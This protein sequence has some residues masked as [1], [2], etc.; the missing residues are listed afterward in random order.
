MARTRAEFL[1]ATTAAAAAGAALPVRAQTL[2]PLRVGTAPADS[3]AQAWYAQ[4]MGFFTKAGLNV[5]VQLFNSGTA[6]ASAVAGGSLD[7]AIT[8]PIPLA[9]AHV[10]GVPFVIVCSATVNTP[11]APTELICVRKSGSIHQASDL[12]GKTA[13]VNTLRTLL[14][15]GLEVYLA[16]SN[17]AISSMRVVEMSFAEMGPAIDRGQI[18]A[19]VFTEPA[20]SKALALNDV[21]IL[22]DPLPLISPRFV[23]ACWFSTRD[24]VSR[25]PEVVKRFASVMYDTARWA[26]RNHKAS[27]PILVKYTKMDPG[28]VDKIIR[29]DFAEQT[30]ASEYQPLL[31]ACTKFGYLPKTVAA[32]DLLLA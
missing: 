24:F 31:D 5:D 20:L 32:S 4:D 14:Q 18:D 8:T 26:N 6:A 19:A 21:R 25:N 1:A 3:F 10:R 11:K 23:A 9:N 16:K 2:P 15:L 29:V 17:I 28:D 12:V 13:A 27:A 30:R 7:I 22:V